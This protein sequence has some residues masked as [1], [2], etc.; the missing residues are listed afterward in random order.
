MTPESTNGKGLAASRVSA[1]G[2]LVGYQDGAVV[3]RELL[4][5]GT[6]TV[7]AFAFDEGQGLSEHTTPFDAL[8]HVLEGEAEIVIAGTPHRVPAGAMILMPGGQPHA[9]RAIQRFKMILTMIR[10]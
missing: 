1:A 4:R 7:T 5:K 6:G 2:D 9:L 10:S 8:A 3:S